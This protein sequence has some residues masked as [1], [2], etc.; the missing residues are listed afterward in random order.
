MNEE[1]KFLKKIH[2]LLIIKKVYLLPKIFQILLQNQI[3]LVITRLRIGFPS[4]FGYYLGQIKVNKKSK[5]AIV[6]MKG[7]S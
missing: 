4:F 6:L 5:K 3:L 2:A 1:S 7:S